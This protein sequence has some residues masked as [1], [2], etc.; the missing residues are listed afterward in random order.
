ML[1]YIRL[2][3]LIVVN[4]ILFINLF[5][6][7]SQSHKS[8]PPLIILFCF[9]NFMFSEKRASDLLDYYCVDL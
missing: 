4:P 8:D 1:L 5:T 6:Q 7:S 9:L 2:Y 3:D